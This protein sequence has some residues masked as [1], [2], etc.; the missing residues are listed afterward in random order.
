MFHQFKREEGNAG[1]HVLLSFHQ[2]CMEGLWLEL[3]G[4]GTF[5]ILGR[6][7]DDEVKTGD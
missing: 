3:L 1:E 7:V 2:V 4:G 5:D 6:L